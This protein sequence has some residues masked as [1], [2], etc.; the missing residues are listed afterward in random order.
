MAILDTRRYTKLRGL[1][2]SKINDIRSRY[3]TSGRTSRS[4]VSFTSKEKGLIIN[5]LKDFNSK[6]PD[7]QKYAYKTGQNIGNSKPRRLKVPERIA[8][9]VNSIR[10]QIESV[11]QDVRKA[12]I[13]QKTNTRYLESR[14]HYLQAQL[15]RKVAGGSLRQNLQKEL[16]KVQKVAGIGTGTNSN[17]RAYIYKIRDKVSGKVYVGQTVKNPTTRFREHLAPVNTGSAFDRVAKKLGRNRLELEVL[18]TTTRRNLDK[19]EA[20]YIAKFNATN[21]SKGFN[22]RR[23]N[24]SSLKT[25]RKYTAKKNPKYA[26]PKIK[27]I[28]RKS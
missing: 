21:P 7:L 14:I 11:P 25:I 17:A 1:L 3:K 2:R 5:R 6:L 26:A 27:I 28:K 10:R 8:K 15:S 24:L 20:K 12:R 23:G 18:K 16:R 19:L 4:A 22:T 9:L 13:T